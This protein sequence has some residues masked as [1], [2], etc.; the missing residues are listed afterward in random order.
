MIQKVCRG[1]MN[2]S[3]LEQL[4]YPPN[5]LK[6]SIKSMG[7][8]EKEC[9]HFEVLLKSCKM[10]NILYRNQLVPP[11]KMPN[12]TAFFTRTY[13]RHLATL[14]REGTEHVRNNV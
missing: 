1:L 13:P 5:T 12:F 6:P 8:E 10:S 4:V 11:Y 14:G 3:N 9:C 7:I 2:R